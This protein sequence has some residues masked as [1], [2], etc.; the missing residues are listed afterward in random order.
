[1]RRLLLAALLL[2]CG[3]SEPPPPVAPDA[4]VWTNATVVTPGGDAVGM[5]TAGGLITDVWT[6]AVPDG[7]TG[8]RVDLGG[9]VVLP[10]LVDAHAHLRGIGRAARQLRLVGTDS[11]AAVAEL[12]RGA[13]DRA[14]GSWIRGR[15][16]DQNDWSETSF[17]TAATLD[18]V[19]PDHPVWLTRVD[20][21]AVWVNS[22]VLEM[23]GVNKDTPDPPG[24]S[25]QRDASGAPTGVFVDAAI[26]LVAA[27]L[28][29]PTAQEIRDDLLRGIA[30][31]QE[32][33]LTGLHDMGVGPTVLKQ[34][35]QLEAEGR[36][37]LR[38][39]AYLADG[40]DLVARIGTPPDRDGL[41]QV[42]GVK[43][44]ADGALGSRGAALKTSYSDAPE[45]RGLL[46]KTPEEMARTVAAVHE[47]GY[48]AAI[49]AIGDQG[50]SI[51][52][53]A[54]AAAQGEDTTRRHRVEHAQVVDPVDFQRFAA[55]QVVASMQPTHATS[56]MPWAEARV[57]PERI[58]GAYAWRRMLDAGVALAFGS[59]APVEEHAPRFGLH[60]AVTRTSVD[61]EPTGGWRT[62]EAVTFDEALAGFTTGAAF[63]AHRSG[64]TLAAGLPADFV[65]VTSDPR[66]QGAALL[67]LAVQRTVVA[68]E[69]VFPRP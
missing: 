32:A 31:C 43:L 64:G 57:G 33:G 11:E 3:A 39:S 53:D 66:A 16:W 26:D 19:A 46:Q 23:A 14:A 35:Q 42:P 4:V 51:A 44:F 12:V 5:R 56:D 50:I 25:I 47:A 38:V 41:L 29:A 21:H 62:M 65:V 15:G 36:L 60:A 30:L 24:G 2:G 13:T 27:Q 8:A 18:A 6:D 10:G 63:A 61:G 67:D 40:D 54:I 68:G 55:L 58:V 22:R 28:P 49:H 48:Q 45:H 17:P 59:D 34:L 20:G 37:D 7:A 69:T 52:L 9:A 1:M